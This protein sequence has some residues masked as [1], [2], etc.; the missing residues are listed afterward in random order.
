MQG[1]RKGNKP[2]QSTNC[3]NHNIDYLEMLRGL[4][5]LCKDGELVLCLDNNAIIKALNPQLSWGE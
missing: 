1:N 4:R 5:R 2:N 3:N